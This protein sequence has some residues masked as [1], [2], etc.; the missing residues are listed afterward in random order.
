MTPLFEVI[1]VPE[2][3]PATVDHRRIRLEVIGVPH[4]QGSKSAIMVGDKAV[5]VEGKSGSGRMRHEA[6]RTAVANCCR[7]YIS[8]DRQ[9]PLTQPV[10]L[11]VQFWMPLP[12]S[13]P[14]R[15]RHASKP[16]LDKL[17]RATMDAMVIGGL[18]KDDALVTELIAMKHYAR[19]GP[20]GATIHIDLLGDLE[21]EDREA[22]K[23]E[24]RRLRRR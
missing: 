18:L 11:T 20:A 16:D 21:A 23:A 19:S 24:A 1:D 13:D 14:H 3:E 4:P 5:I 2:N 12:Q 8:A 10:R 22:S 15:T 7:A 6:W 9:P 17:V